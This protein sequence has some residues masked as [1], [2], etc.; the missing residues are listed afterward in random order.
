VPC[1]RGERSQVATA[2]SVRAG[3]VIRT[4]VGAE[5]IK[6]KANPIDLLTEVDGEVQTLLEAAINDAF[7]AH[8]FLVC[9]R[10]PPTLVPHQSSRSAAEVTRAGACGIGY[11]GGVGHVLTAQP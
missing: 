7:P 6:T 3:E 2:A 8:G 9:E 5:V 4:K 10:S 11:S 1:M